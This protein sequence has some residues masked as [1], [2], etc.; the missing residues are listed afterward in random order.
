M[1]YGSPSM[2]CPPPTLPS[3]PVFPL[4][5]APNCNC[6]AQG[7]CLRCLQPAAHS[8][9]YGPNPCQPCSADGSC[10][11]C[12]VAG[13]CRECASGWRM[14]AAGACKPQV[15]QQ[16]K[17]TSRPLLIGCQAVFHAS[18]SHAL[19]QTHGCA[20]SLYLLLQRGRQVRGL[21]PQALSAWGRK[22]DATLAGPPCIQ[23]HLPSPTHYVPLRPCSLP[24]FHPGA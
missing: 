8:A 16:A 11:A 5:C 12:F 2:P 7:K 20:V 9:P 15:S 22:Q 18:T 17:V 3:L 1:A 23:H 10:A 21:E 13:I 6:D 14:T 4:Q 24:P 19:A